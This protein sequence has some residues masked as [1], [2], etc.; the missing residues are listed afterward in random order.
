MRIANSVTTMRNNTPIIE[1]RVGMPIDMMIKWAKNGET[2][3]LPDPRLSK[4]NVLGNHAVFS[5]DG[6]WALARLLRE[7][8]LPESAFDTDG[9]PGSQVLEFSIPTAFNPNC[10]RGK[11]VMPFERKSEP[12]RLYMRLIMGTPVQVEPGKDGAAPTGE[13]KNRIFPVPSF[14]YYS[15]QYQ[16]R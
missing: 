16:R 11:T 6:R 15:P 5:Y 4:L 1:W 14:P 8:V 12:A 13:D 2:V 7:H 3:P 9:V 10:Y